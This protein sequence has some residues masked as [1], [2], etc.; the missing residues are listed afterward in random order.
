MLPVARRLV[1]G[2]PRA[3]GAEPPPAGRV[4]TKAATNTMPLGGHAER[5]CQ[6][7]HRPGDSSRHAG[8]LVAGPNQE[9]R[10]GWG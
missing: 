6:R 7:S 1:E 4:V 10:R 8:V 2:C 3:L 5:P 9:R